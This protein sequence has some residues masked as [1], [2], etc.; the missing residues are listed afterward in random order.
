MTKGRL[1]VMWA[2]RIVLKPREIP[3]AMKVSIREIPVTISE[4]KIGILLMPMVM[5]FGTRFML[6]M[7][8][9]ARV[10]RMV[11]ARV[12]MKAMSSVL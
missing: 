6:L 8:R 5:F 10:P 12:E 4:F 1:K 3:K 11:A 9:A 2:I 7:P